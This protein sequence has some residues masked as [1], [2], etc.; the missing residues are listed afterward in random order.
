[1]NSRERFIN[2]VSGKPV[3]ALP[4]NIW[5]SDSAKRKY[6]EFS[7]VSKDEMEEL[8]NPGKTY[9]GKRYEVL[10]ENGK[11]D[12]EADWYD[13]FGVGWKNEPGDGGAVN[14]VAPLKDI[15]DLKSYR[16]PDVKSV[17]SFQNAAKQ[18][19]EE[20]GIKYCVAYQAFGTFF[21]KYRFLRGFE[22]GLVDMMLEQDKVEGFLDRLLEYQLEIARNY[23][24]CGVDAVETGDDVALQ[25]G[26][27]INPEIWRKLIKPRM[28]KLI[29]FY[30]SAGVQ[31]IHHCCGD[32]YDIIKDY[33][34]IGIDCL[35]PVQPESMSIEKL[36]EEFGSDLTFYGGVGVQSVLQHGTPADVDKAVAR[37]IEILGSRRRYIIGA[38][39][40]V[41]ECI[42]CE[43]MKAFFE[44]V[45]K[46]RK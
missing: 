45:A 36:V 25:K 28:A 37:T 20:K 18:V 17:Y 21:N 11:A 29:A 22:N 43:N 1:M 10:K 15:D 35:N 13:E 5:M 42:P 19:S 32:T 40:T 31:S 8:V 9:S 38:S 14:T 7:G 6:M 16:L 24:A 27:V 4:I 46:Y 41:Q 34:E 26:L 33:I 23:I 2:A 3:D 44:A 12:L 39:H 30:K